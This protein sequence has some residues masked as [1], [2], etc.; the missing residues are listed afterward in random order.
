MKNRVT[1]QLLI[2]HNPFHLVEISP[3][4]LIASLGA[5]SIVL[6]GL[7]YINLGLGFLPLTIFL[8][9]RLISF[10]W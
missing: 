5:A 8:L 2:K 7:V 1:T 6:S 3:W 9:I 10:A 4:P